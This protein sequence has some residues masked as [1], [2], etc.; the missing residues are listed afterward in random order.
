MFAYAVAFLLSWVSPPLAL[1]VDAAMALYYAF[2]QATIQD[3][4]PASLESG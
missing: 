4:A 2:D 1:A 3:D